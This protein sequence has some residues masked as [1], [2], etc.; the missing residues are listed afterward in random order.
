M[1]DI[2]HRQLRRT[3]GPDYSGLRMATPDGYAGWLLRMAT[4]DGYSGWLLRTTP[5]YSGFQMATPDGYPGLLR[6]A[7]PDYSG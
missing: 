5:G 1:T 6:M 2:R 4:P 7:T 3:T